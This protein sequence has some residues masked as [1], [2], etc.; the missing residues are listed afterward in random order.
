M[1][2]NNRGTVTA[3]SLV[4]SI[5]F[6]CLGV[7]AFVWKPVNAEVKPPTFAVRCVKLDEEKQTTVFELSGAANV[8]TSNKDGDVVL[9]VY[10]KDGTDQ[11]HKV[12]KNQL[13]SISKE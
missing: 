12:E 9:I 11:M 5:F 6:I 7:A 4:T 10:L 8:R 3:F 2:V 13:C 1:K